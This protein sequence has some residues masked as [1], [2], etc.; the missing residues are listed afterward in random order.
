SCVD[1]NSKAL[2]LQLIPVLDLKGGQVVR[3][4][5][6]ERQHYRPIVTPLAATSDPVDVLRGLLAIHRFPI[7]YTADLD[8]IE[9]RGDN[10]PALMRLEAQARV[11]LWVD[12]GVAGRNAIN[13]WLDRG[14]GDVVI[15]SETLGEVSVL[16][17]LGAAERIILSL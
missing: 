12:S 11:R 5:M 4:R 17:Q 7:V 1:A 9:R 16:E 14:V 3:A 8:A 6:G 15:G 10:R 13:E 2:P